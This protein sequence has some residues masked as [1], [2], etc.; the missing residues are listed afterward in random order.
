MTRFNPYFGDVSSAQ[1]HVNMQDYADAGHMLIAIKASEGTSYVNPYHRGQ[2][3]A[4]GSRH[5]AVVHYHFA[6]PDVNASPE[7][8]AEHFIRVTDGLRGPFDYLVCDVERAAPAGWSHDPAWFRKFDIYVRAHTW[9]RTILYAS[10]S[11]LQISD[12]WFEDQPKRVWD[13]DWS[14]DPD[15][16]PAGYSVIFRQINDGVVGPGPL[17]LA[18]IGECD[19][20]Y[21]DR[22]VFNHLHEYRR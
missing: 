19:V 1:P 15:Y 13:A 14:T 3:L 2:A 9:Y 5:V 10:K 4:A 18:G 7:L 11:T 17:T 20:N 8:E 16:A 6:R 12:A 21:M 22:Q